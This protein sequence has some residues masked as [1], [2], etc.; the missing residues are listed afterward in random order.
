MYKMITNS[1]INGPSTLHATFLALLYTQLAGYGTGVNKVYGKPTNCKR[2]SASS[3]MANKFAKHLVFWCSP[4]TFYYNFFFCYLNW[5]DILADSVSDENKGWHQWPEQLCHEDFTYEVL[6]LFNNIM[7][8]T[9][10]YDLP[11]SIR[12]FGWFSVIDLIKTFLWHK[13]WKEICYENNS[14]SGFDLMKNP[15]SQII[16]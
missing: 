10:I 4:L 9:V 5:F 7:S 15:Q 16:F 12:F 8:C 1:D 14:M 11:D 2:G 13:W 3:K 6:I